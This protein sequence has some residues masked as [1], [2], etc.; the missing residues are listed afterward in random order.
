MIATN[1]SRVKLERNANA[2]S[3]VWNE[4]AMVFIDDKFSNHIQCE[5]C[6]MLLKWKHRDGTTG[7]KNHSASCAKNKGS[8]SGIVK[9]TAMGFAFASGK[10]LEGQLPSSVKSEVAD[11]VVLMCAKDIR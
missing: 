5:H 4:Y 9:L 8:S 2:T 6:C 7:L 11:A 10:K 3:S 1:S